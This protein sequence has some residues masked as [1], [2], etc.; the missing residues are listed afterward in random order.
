M[1]T[2]GKPSTNWERETLVK[3][4]RRQS[5]GVQNVY[6]IGVEKDH[7]FLLA[8]GEI[9][10]NCFN[11]SHSMAYG[12][13]T[14]QTAYLKANYPIEYMAA[15]LTA[16]SDNQDKVQRYIAT[17]LNMGIAVEPPDINRSG[18]DFTPLSGKILFGLNAVRNVGHAAILCILES[19]E[20]EGPFQNLADLCDRVDLR[21][22]N[23]R[24]LESLIQCGAMDC[25]N[26]NRHQ[27]LENLE[28]VIDWAHTR[29][30]DRASGQGSIFDLFGDSQEEQPQKK[31]LE[32]APKAPEVADFTPQEKLRLEKD[33]LGFYI[34]DHPLKSAMQSSRLLG[35]TNLSD[36][37]QQPEEAAISAIVMLSSIKPITTKKGD[38]MA[39]IQIE[40]LTGKAEGVVFPKTYERVQSFL[41]TDDSLMLWGKIDRRDDRTQLIIEDVEPIEKVKMLMVE[42]NPLQAGDMQEQHR[43]RTIL[44]EY[45]GEKE[46]AKIPVVAVVSA[47]NQR[48]FVRFGSQYQVSSGESAA[49]A[50]ESAGFPARLQPLI[51]N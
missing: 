40:D 12:Y 44:Q 22:V 47:N 37:E 13:V 4:V 6:D 30:K 39:I 34:S 16:N 1:D 3:I 2:I 29:A 49:R 46:Q 25:L 19:R 8:S 10:S 51:S 11:K 32:Q 48:Q 28:Y 14:Y 33:L 9:A 42:L 5:V 45:R 36:L 31:G 17:C 15:L 18:V 23:R 35:P 7:N 24:A 38:R 27:L 41:N 26:S 50:L 21:T 20:K 43:L